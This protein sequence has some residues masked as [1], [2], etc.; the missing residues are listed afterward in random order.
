MFSVSWVSWYAKLAASD[1]SQVVRL[2]IASALL[3]IE[4]G[5]RWPVLAGLLSH[6]E[7]AKDHNLPLLYWYATEGSVSADPVRGLGILKE[8]KIPKVREFIARRLAGAKAVA[9]N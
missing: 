8:T 2:Y 1:P 5:R 3:R 6:P 4:P 7:D 9:S